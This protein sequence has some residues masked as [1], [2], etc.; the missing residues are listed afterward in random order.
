MENAAVAGRPVSWR[1]FVRRFRCPAPACEVAR[2]ATQIP[3]LT[4]KYARRSLVPKRALEAIAAALAGLSTGGHTRPIGQPQRAPAPA[5]GLAAA[6]S[7]TNAT[8]LFREIVAC[9][10]QGP[11]WRPARYFFDRPQPGLLGR[12]VRYDCEA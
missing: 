3:E 9:G 12:S 11:S 7:E 4:W 6:R 1:L 5:A 2:F 10:Y 8:A